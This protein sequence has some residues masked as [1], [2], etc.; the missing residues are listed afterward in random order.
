MPSL[1]RFRGTKIPERLPYRTRSSSLPVWL[2]CAQLQASHAARIL[3]GPLAGLS[4]QRGPRACARELPVIRLSG[5]DAAPLRAREQPSVHTGSTLSSRPRARFGA[6]PR[7]QATIPFPGSCRSSLSPSL[8]LG[9][10]AVEG[11]IGVQHCTPHPPALRC[12]GD[13]S[14]SIVMS[15]MML[16]APCATEPNYGRNRASA[17]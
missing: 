13:A 11:G 17:S 2:R 10:N 3:C 6:R 14:A 8:G 9:W 5:D 12:G 15:T 1:I 16:G 7:S 4:F